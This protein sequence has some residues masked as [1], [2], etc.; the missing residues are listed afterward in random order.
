MYDTEAA[1]LR[2]TL[3]LVIDALSLSK[4]KDV[5]RGGCRFCNVLVCVLDAFFEHWRGAR[6]RVH[7]DLIEKKPI[8][9]TVGGERWKDETIEIYAGSGRLHIPSLVILPSQY[10]EKKNS[11]DYT[12]VIDHKC[13]L[14]RFLRWG[15]NKYYAATY[16]I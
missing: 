15:E 8:K 12:C 16:C 14:A 6:A 11:L 1:D 5:A 3:H 9:V 10:P 7:V 2:A 4:I 13:L